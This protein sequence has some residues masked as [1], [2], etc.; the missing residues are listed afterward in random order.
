M[1][2]TIVTAVGNDSS[3]AQQYFDTMRRSEHLEPEKALLI[4]L[5]E[6]AIDTYRKFSRAQ[7]REGKE[8]FREAKEWIMARDDHWIFAFNNVCE[9]LGLNPD[10]IRRGLREMRA[11]APL[12]TASNHRRAGRRRAA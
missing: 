4:A 11:K 8:Q 7:D 2:E 9:L 3:L 6:D 12:P 5:L 1:M 10:Y